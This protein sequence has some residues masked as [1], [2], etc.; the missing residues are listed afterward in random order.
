MHLDQTATAVNSDDQ[1]GNI[2]TIG[3]FKLTADFDPGAGVYHL[4]SA[5]DLGIF[6]SKLNSS[7]IC[8]LSYLLQN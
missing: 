4:T 8:G 3:N 5:A 7:G 6:V 2:Y 1:S